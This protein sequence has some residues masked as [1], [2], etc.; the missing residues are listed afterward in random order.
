MAVGEGEETVLKI[1]EYGISK[2]IFGLAFR[3]EGG[4]V[5]MTP[6]TPLCREN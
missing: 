4:G 5:V 2:G 1:P 3:K 6:A